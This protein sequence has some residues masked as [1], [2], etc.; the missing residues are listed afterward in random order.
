MVKAPNADIMTGLHFP[1]SDIPKQAREL[2]KINRIRI[3]YDRDAETARLVCDLQSSP[4]PSFSFNIS[5]STNKKARSAEK[6]RTSK[7]L[8]TYLTRT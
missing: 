7:F 6:R 1:A 8:L 4:T 2:Y 5:A 3:L